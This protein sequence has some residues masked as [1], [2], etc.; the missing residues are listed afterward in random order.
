MPPPSSTRTVLEQPHPHTN[1][2]YFRTRIFLLVAIVPLLI[3]LVLRSF[4]NT[5]PPAT[6]NQQIVQLTHQLVRIPSPLGSETDVLRYVRQW[7]LDRE[8]RVVTH[9]VHNTFIILATLAAPSQVHILL[10]THL[11]VV[12]I[13][14]PPR[15]TPSRLYGRGAV[16]AK[17]Q[18]AALML[19]ANRIRNP[20]VAVLLVVREET[21]H[22]GM[23]AAHAFQLPS[24]ITFLNAEPTQ[25]RLAT[26]QKGL[27]KVWITARGISAHSGYPNLGSSAIHALVSVLSTV[28]NT[29]PDSGQTN[30]NV[31]VIEGGKAANVL[32]ADSRALLVWRI[33]TNTSHVLEQLE[34]ILR[35]HHNVSYH[36]VTRNEAMELYAPSASAAEFGTCSV[37][38]N[39]DIPYYKGGYDK[40]I[41]FGAGSIEQAHTEDEWIST[42]D[43]LELPYQLERIVKEML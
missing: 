34:E 29:W 17:G 42:K 26:A 4:L 37:S 8:W 31:G 27:L 35:A 22:A 32:A 25:G 40:A 7:F 9:P 3:F 41:L 28:R 38:Y 30:V 24:N 23:A 10:S 19:V 18:A 14:L 12:P 1:N 13:S 33:S 20:R 5:S 11:D 16:D 43:L 36:V 6:N 21:D 39:T 2:N 15:L